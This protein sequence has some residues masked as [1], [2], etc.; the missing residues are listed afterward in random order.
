LDVAGFAPRYSPDGARL[1]FLNG[2]KALC[3][4][5]AD[6][7]G[8]RELVTSHPYDPANPPSWS[9]DGQW[10]L[11]RGPSQLELVRVATGEII[12]LTYSGGLF[13]PA[14]KP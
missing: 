10:I 7:S 11:I 5:N 12:P 4:V 8:F 6:G 3:V 2:Y 9:S 13:Q 1:L 14:V